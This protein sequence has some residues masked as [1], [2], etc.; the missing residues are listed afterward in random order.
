MIVFFYNSGRL[1]NRLFMA[2]YLMVLGMESKQKVLNL[3][4]HEYHS[5]FEGTKDNPCRLFPSSRRGKTLF[6]NHKFINRLFYRI[7][8]WTKKYP[9]LQALRLATVYG[10]PYKTDLDPI[11]ANQ[12]GQEIKKIKSLLIFYDSPWHWYDSTNY[13]P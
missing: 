11:N 13:T 5:Y 12:I 9:L 1:G 2:T 10:L 8:L 6:R 3:S 4:F 7:Y